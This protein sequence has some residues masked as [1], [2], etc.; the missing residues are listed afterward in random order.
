M[1]SAVHVA[2]LDS[3]EQLL[4]R[5]TNMAQMSIV[6]QCIVHLARALLVSPHLLVL[7]KPF[8]TLDEGVRRRVVTALRTFVAERGLAEEG[9]KAER[10]LRT[11]VISC[12]S[13]DEACDISD[14]TI[15]IGEAAAH[16][17]SA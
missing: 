12:N 16:R 3:M 8:A 9:P 14:E 17:R 2:Q 13:L 6:D 4:L 15:L 5:T 11:V 7:H 10:L 1:E